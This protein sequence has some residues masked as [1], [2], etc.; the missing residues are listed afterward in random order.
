MTTENQKTL[1]SAEVAA[2]YDRGDTGSNSRTVTINGQEI[3]VSFIT[4]NRK[5][6]DNLPTPTRQYKINGKRVSRAVAM[7]A[8]K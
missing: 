8:A 4:V 3:T 5:C 7:E 2:E 1:I 6:Y